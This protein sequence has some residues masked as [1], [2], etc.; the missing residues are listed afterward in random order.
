MDERR[1]ELWLAANGIEAIMFDLD[2]TLIDRQGAF[3]RYCEHL[4][5]ECGVEPTAED[6]EYLVETDEFGYVVRAIWSKNIVRRFP[7]CQWDART[8]H[9][10]FTKHFIRY[11][12]PNPQVTQLV[13]RFCNNL[14]VAIVSNGESEAQRA[15]IAQAELEGLVPHVVISEEVRSWKPNGKIFEAGRKKLD[16]PFEKILYV[17]DDAK[18]DIW[19]ASRLG[20]QTCWIECGRTWETEAKAHMVGVKPDFI[21]PRFECFDD[22][23]NPLCEN[24]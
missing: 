2:N 8:I 1:L 5:C 6:I 15:K 11:I 14:P 16:L 20:M 17:G 7:L 21:L 19:G 24:A 22:L 10:H 13:K 12:E 23:L 4:L 18:R 9:K 3:E